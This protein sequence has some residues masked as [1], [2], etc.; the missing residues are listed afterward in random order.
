MPFC[1]RVEDDTTSL[2]DYSFWTSVVLM[3]KQVI[4][5]IDHLVTPAF[6]VFADGKSMI[7]AEQKTVYPTQI[8]TE[9]SKSGIFMDAELSF[10]GYTVGLCFTTPNK[11]AE[12]NV[13]GLRDAKK[14]GLLEISLVRAQEWLFKGNAEGH[15]KDRLKE[16]IVADA[17]I[18]RWLSHPREKKYQAEN[19]VKITPFRL[20]DYLNQ[21][22]LNYREDS[23]KKFQCL[24]CEKVWQGVGY[25]SA[26]ETHLYAAV[27]K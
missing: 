14:T 6:A 24:M 23:S 10:G 15:Y 26:C 3:A 4:K 25:C 18:K 2:C 5:E 11:F 19:G 8:E 7:F 13:G 1:S 12:P 21:Q 27:Y 20:T 22:G 16:K 17:G 9:T